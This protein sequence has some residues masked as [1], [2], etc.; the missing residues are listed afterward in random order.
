MTGA[1]TSRDFLSAALSY[2]SI[3]N[4]LFTLK[5]SHCYNA[6]KN[7]R[8]LLLISHANNDQCFCSLSSVVSSATD[9]RLHYTAG[10]RESLARITIT[11]P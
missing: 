10:Q 1:I 8:A 6:S 2:V 5:M 4:F 9:I 11:E 7:A 3:L